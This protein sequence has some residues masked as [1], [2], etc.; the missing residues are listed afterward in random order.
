MQRFSRKSADVISIDKGGPPPPPHLTKE[1]A[2]EWRAIIGTMPAN[3]FTRECQPA[4]ALLVQDICRSRL[5]TTQIAK[6]QDGCLK[7]ENGLR[8]LDKLLAMQE[9]E[10]RSVTALMRTLRL[11]L[12][13]RLDK[14]VA[15]ARASAPG[16]GASY[17]DLM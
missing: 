8:C 11:T 4:L 10:T 13:S 9:R 3:W 15:G 2:E 14:R 5:L 1:E 7:N 16:A 17:Y 12:Q 6:V